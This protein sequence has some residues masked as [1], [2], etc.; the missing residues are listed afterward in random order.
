MHLSIRGRPRRG[1]ER[2]PL[3]LTTDLWFLGSQEERGGTAG[4]D[5]G[6]RYANDNRAA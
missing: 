3:G 4:S 1:G 5:T 2:F 6:Y